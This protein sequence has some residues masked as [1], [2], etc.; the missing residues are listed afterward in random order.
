LLVTLFIFKFQSVVKLIWK[1]KRLVQM[2]IDW[3]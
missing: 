3:G 2:C 1:L